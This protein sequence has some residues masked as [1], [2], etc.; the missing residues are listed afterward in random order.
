MTN[1]EKIQVL[2]PDGFIIDFAKP[3]YNSYKKAI[4]AIEKWKKRFEMQGYY[5]SNYGRIPLAELDDHLSIRDI[6]TTKE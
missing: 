1:I 5:S 3:H 4:E 2:S 6:N